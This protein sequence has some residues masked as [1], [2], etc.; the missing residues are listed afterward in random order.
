MIFLVES[1]RGRVISDSLRAGP[2]FP[3]LRE[4]PAG[5]RWTGTLGTAAAAMLSAVSPTTVI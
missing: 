2:F 1:E 4:R 3:F 5:V